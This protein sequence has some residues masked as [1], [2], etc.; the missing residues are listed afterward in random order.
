M[1]NPAGF[2]VTTEAGTLGDVRKKEPMAEVMF[3][4]EARVA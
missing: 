1:P 2:V 3:D 4:E